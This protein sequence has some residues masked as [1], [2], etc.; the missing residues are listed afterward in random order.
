MGAILYPSAETIGDD[1][2]ECA[3]HKHS[4]F[5]SF[6]SQHN[7]TLSSLHRHV[8]DA[9]LRIPREE[10]ILAFWRGAAPTVAR[11]MV[12]NCTQLASYDEAKSRLKALGMQE[13][14]PLHLISSLASALVYC[15]ASLP[16]DIVK[17]RM[18]DFKRS[19]TV[20]SGGPAYSSVMGTLRYVVEREGV[21][22]LW[23]GFVPYF[24]RGGG[25]TVGM[26]LF[27]EQY[28]ALFK[29]YFK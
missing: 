2:F 4:F 26:F 20:S 21:A 25:H 29:K 3:L 14:I 15:S 7:F 28:R 5:F 1:L 16:L 27:L 17:T 23:K 6:T 12:V 22:A 10:G 9:L 24:M 18:Q 19:Q 13:G 8:G 11:S